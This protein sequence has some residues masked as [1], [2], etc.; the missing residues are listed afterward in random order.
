MGLPN[1]IINFISQASSAIRRGNRGTVLLIIKEQLKENQGI[2]RL[3]EVQ[4]I[5]K[6]F[7]EENK[8]YISRA[9]LGGI[10]PI[11]DAVIVSA[12]NVEDALKDVEVTKFDYLVGPH[13]IEEKDTILL[14]TF[15]KTLRVNK[16][17]KVKAILPN[18]KADHE[19]VINF[20]TNN[21]KVK[22]KVYSTSQYCSRIAGLIAGT[23][24]QESVTYK[25][26]QEVTDVPKFTK[27]EL[28]EK[29]DAGEFVIFHDGKKV[30]VARGVNSLV[31]V[32]ETKGDDMKSI[33]IV[34]IIDLIYTDIKTTA[35][36][37]YIGKFANN[38]KNKCKLIVAIQAYFEALESENLLD[39]GS[40]VEIDIKSNL[41]YLKDHNVDV[42][43]M[44]V[45][46]IKEANT[47][48]YV[49]LDGKIKPLNAIEDI[50]LNLFM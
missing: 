9:F 47:G 23:P 49:F 44:K 22:E 26:L 16:G 36:D 31:T 38:Y 29:I 42:K 24:L 33:K 35:E 2:F 50:S 40:N 45:Q 30:K 43:D 41:K 34:D 14:A 18:M 3:E 1:I 8:E 32:G 28:D 5:P 25:V 37:V 4:D 39:K 6:K 48:T 7:T 15:I 19:G 27:K 21:I 46:D 12:G 17:I 10:N 11:K 20:T 13:D